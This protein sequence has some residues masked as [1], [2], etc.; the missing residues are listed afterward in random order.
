MVE[1]QFNAEGTTCHFQLDRGVLLHQDVVQ[2]PRSIV[3]D[4]KLNNRVF[5]AT[6]T[7]ESSA[8]TKYYQDR[9]DNAEK[10]NLTPG[11]V[12]KYGGNYVMTIEM[13][14]LA[15]GNIPKAEPQ[16]KKP[17]AVVGATN[18]KGV[19]VNQI[20]FYGDNQLM[21]VGSTEG[22]GQAFGQAEQEGFVSG[23]V[24]KIHADNGELLMSKRING[25]DDNGDEAE[26]DIQ[27]ICYHESE[28]DAIYVVGV[29]HDSGSKP[30]PFVTK[31]GAETLD[32]IWEKVF[33]ATAYSYAVA[34]GVSENKGMLNG[35]SGN[36]LYVAGNIQDSGAITDLTTSQGGDDIFV[37]QLSTADGSLLWVKQIGH[38]GDDSLAEGGDGLIVLDGI[39]PDGTSAGIL[40]MGDT[41]SSL[42]ATSRSNDIFIAHVDPSGNASEHNPNNPPDTLPINVPQKVGPGNPDNDSP[43]TNVPP[44]ED[45]SITNPPVAISPQSSVSEVPS[46]NEDVAVKGQ[47]IYFLMSIVILI[48]VCAF[49]YMCMK[50]KQKEKVTERALV[51]SYLQAFD[52]EDIDVR[53]SAT[54]GWHG[55]YVGKLAHGRVH[56][57]VDNI[58]IADTDDDENDDAGGGGTL[59]SGYSHSSIVKDSLFVDYDSTPSY[60]DGYETDTVCR[61]DGDDERS[62]FVRIGQN[63][64]DSD[65]ISSEDDFN[66]ARLSRKGRVE[67]QQVKERWGKE[68]I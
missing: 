63:Y 26:T 42:F 5:V 34:C 18:G 35:H 52:V 49:G 10:V 40:I 12:F 65:T 53:N 16:W 13:L 29:V 45:F 39:G 11:G 8:V 1:L 9:I 55:T 58:D 50:Q 60:G 22:S 54:G 30:S 28:P 56:G 25:V 36:V 66:L 7:T 61:D 68:I 57:A 44:V 43:N 41:G 15:D 38:A 21:V 51:F 64:V 46:Q 24:S 33:P 62:S 14:R 47:K 6:M 32:H 19:F 20:M 2:I 37:M 31:L 48:L 4:P 3:V 27:A 59:L 67:D 23:F 17:F